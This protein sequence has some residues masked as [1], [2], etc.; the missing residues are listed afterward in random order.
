MLA[1]STGNLAGPTWLTLTSL[2]LKMINSIR[3]TE[4]E[5]AMGMGNR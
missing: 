1:D 3:I 5:L 2:D 4:E